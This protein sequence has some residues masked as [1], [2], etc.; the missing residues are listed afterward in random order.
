MSAI[1]SL[2][3]VDPEASSYKFNFIMSQTFLGRHIYAAGGNPDAA[4]LSGISV[5]KI[6]YL[7]F[8]SIVMLAGLSVI[9]FASRLQLLL[10]LMLQ[11][12][13]ERSDNISILS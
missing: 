4:E 1:G 7:V 2:Q 5:K 10:Y 13:E 3:A 8:G 6:T 12:V 11:P 9:M